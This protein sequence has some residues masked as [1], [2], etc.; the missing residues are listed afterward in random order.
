MCPLA[1]LANRYNSSEV[2]Q[3]LPE[4]CCKPL[5]AAVA[6]PAEA[7]LRPEQFGHV[8]QAVSNFLQHQLG[9][10]LQVSSILPA[11][12]VRAQEGGVPTF[13]LF[14]QHAPDLYSICPLNNTPTLSVVHLNLAASF[15]ALYCSE[16]LANAG[17]KTQLQAWILPLLQVLLLLA[18]QSSCC[19]KVPAAALLA[20]RSSCRRARL[21]DKA[22]SDRA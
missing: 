9:N 11:P 6:L 8:R 7:V 14:I 20:S 19:V 10:S 15:C 21:S 13:S 16:A 4:R 22:P 12:A 17:R 3:L 2:L 5:T 18:V 1:S